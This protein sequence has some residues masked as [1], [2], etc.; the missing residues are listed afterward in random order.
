MERRNNSDTVGPWARAMR[1]FAKENNVPLIDQ[2]AMSKQTWA[3][4]G[5]NVGPAFADQT[6]LSGYGG[7][8]LAKNIVRGIKAGVPELARFIVDDYQDMDP[9]KPEPPPAYLQQSPGPGGRSPTPPE[10]GTQPKGERQ[11]PES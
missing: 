10:P 2:W 4:L 5:A 9:A 1:E 8:L 3:A 6:H 11:K 7:Y